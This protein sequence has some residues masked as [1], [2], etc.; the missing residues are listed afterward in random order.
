[1]RDNKRIDM[2]RF[3]VRPGDSD[4]GPTDNQKTEIQTLRSYK[5]Q[6]F[7]GVVPYGVDIWQSWS[8]KLHPRI[9]LMAGFCI[10]GQWH[11][12]E[13]NGQTAPAREADGAWFPIA[14]YTLG[15][16]ADGRGD[17]LRYHIRSHAP[18]KQP[19]S[20]VDSQTIYEVS[21]EPLVR[22]RWYHLVTRI[23]FGYTGGAAQLQIWLDGQEKIN[24]TGINIG[25]NDLKGPHFNFGI[26]RG[27]EGQDTLPEIAYYANMEMSL[28]SLTHRIGNPR[29]L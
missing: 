6:N 22:G 23:R 19:G 20:S 14:V 12:T 8:M 27:F 29:P 9:P 28:S 17:W 15:S 25:Y 24:A 1:M 10:I 26:Y 2:W 3:E 11:A 13:D 18:E 21:G 5:P 4:L 7:N 16:T